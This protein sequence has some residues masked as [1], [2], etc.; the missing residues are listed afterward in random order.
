MNSQREC[1]LRIQRKF[2]NNN[3]ITHILIDK[4]CLS[5]RSSFSLWFCI[6]IDKKYLQKRM[7]YNSYVSTPIEMNG[8]K[9]LHKAEMRC[10]CSIE[11]PSTIQTIS[12]VPLYDWLFG[13]FAFLWNSLLSNGDGFVLFLLWSIVQTSEQQKFLYN[14]LYCDC[15]L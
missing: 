11:H 14:Q 5:L 1:I 10:K 6:F 8:R 2:T 3:I 13:T 15:I 12:A 7:K 9:T 4:V